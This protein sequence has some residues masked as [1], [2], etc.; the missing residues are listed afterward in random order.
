[1]EVKAKTRYVRTAPR[2]MRLVS[3]MIRGMMIADAMRTLKFT[4]KNGAK[5]L[6]KT[7]MSAVAGAEQKGTVNVDNMYV[8]KVWVDEGPTMKRFMPRAQGRATVIR[9]RMSH[10]NIVLDEK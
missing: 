4:N 7:L 8:K 5:V 9:K 6:Y 10:L 1:M 3:D 2:K